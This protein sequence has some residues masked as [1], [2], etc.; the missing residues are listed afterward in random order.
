[1]EE[2]IDLPIFEELPGLESR[3]YGHNFRGVVD[4]SKSLPIVTQAS[5]MTV[6]SGIHAP[7][8]VKSSPVPQVVVPQDT[9]SLLHEF[10]TVFGEVELTHGT[11]TPPQSP[12]VPTYTSVSP[13]DPKEE[14]ISLQ[15]MIP[16]QPVPVV[17]LL[18]IIYNSERKETLFT[19]E[20][21][22]PET[23]SPDLARELAAVDELVRTRVEHLVDISSSHC[24]PDPWESC[25]NG[26][27]SS[28]S[29]GESEGEASVAA[30]PSPCT[31]SSG[32][33]CGSGE[34]MCDDPEW[35]PA[36]I[37]VPAA[38]CQKNSRKRGGST[39]PYSRPG[40]EEKR[41]RKKE[42]N[43]NAAT[44]YRQKKKAEIE[45]ILSEERG[46]EERNAEL[47]LKVGDLSRE[48]KYLKGLMRD[49]FKARGLIK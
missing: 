5:V 10:E 26:N 29:L 31:S 20:Q 30:P 36:C 47:Q 28:S 44:R 21:I 32:S 42:Q 27:I 15:Q 34:E 37:L 8:E 3:C 48:I 2:K 39:K 38:D 19:L 7:T 16:V 45:E 1:L 13:K 25:S 17:P 23:P 18:P 4:I 43:K 41:M 11:L 40:T 46:L 22:V 14:L 49:L 12:P 9:Q 35:I 6:P 33:S 24:V